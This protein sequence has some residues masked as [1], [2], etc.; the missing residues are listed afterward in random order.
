MITCSVP[1]CH[2]R[3]GRFH[4]GEA[5]WICGVHWERITKG[6]RR[7]L[8]RAKRQARKIGEWLPTHERVW[9]ALVRRATPG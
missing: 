7:V 6:E 5:E 8:S 2:R 4:P 9:R 1:G 3:T